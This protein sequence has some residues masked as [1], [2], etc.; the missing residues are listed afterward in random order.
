VLD[1]GIFGFE[2]TDELGGVFLVAVFVYQSGGDSNTQNNDR[3]TRDTGKYRVIGEE[4]I[5]AD[6]LPVSGM[7]RIRSFQAEGPESG[8]FFPDCQCCRN[9]IASFAVRAARKRYSRVV[10][11]SRKGLVSVSSQV[12]SLV[13]MET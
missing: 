10:F 7:E 11:P 9:E 6:S 4:K 1:A 2:E 5:A 8:G 12:S 13:T 3:Q